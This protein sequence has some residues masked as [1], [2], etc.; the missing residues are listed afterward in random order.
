MDFALTEIPSEFLLHLVELQGIPTRPSWIPPTELANA[1]AH[2]QSSAPHQ[3]L[4]STQQLANASAPPMIALMEPRLITISILASVFA[5][6]LAL[7]EP[8]NSMIA[9]AVALTLNSMTFLQVLSSVVPT[10]SNHGPTEVSPSSLMMETPSLLSSSTP[11]H[12]LETTGI[13]DLPTLSALTSLL[14]RLDSERVKEAGPESQERTV[15]LSETFS[16]STLKLLALL[17]LLTPT[18]PPAVEL[19]SSTLTHQR[20]SMVFRSLTLITEVKLPERSLSQ[21]L[22]ALISSCPS[23]RLVTMVRLTSMPF[24]PRM[25]PLSELKMSSLSL[26]T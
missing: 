10:T 7:Q 13:S 23:P 16:S 17:L 4:T 5:P 21:G 19:C 3:R 6:T 11:F 9:N 18:I 1:N 15:F 24:P 8:S 2:L 14:V 20:N 22:L 26:F 25:I 12:G